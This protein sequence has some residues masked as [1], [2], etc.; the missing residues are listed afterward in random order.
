MAQGSHTLFTIKHFS[1]PPVSSR[2]VMA[3]FCIARLFHTSYRIVYIQLSVSDAIP[4]RI[5]IKT[6]LCFQL[7]LQLVR[8]V[9]MN[10]PK[11]DFFLFSLRFSV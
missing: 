10:N 4:V 8:P 5:D 9:F 7:N 3:C 2:A 11:Q 1:F 6:Y